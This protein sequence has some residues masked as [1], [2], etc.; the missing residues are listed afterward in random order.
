MS[1]NKWK[2]QMLFKSFSYFIQKNIYKFFYDLHQGLDSGNSPQ[3]RDLLKIARSQKI[4]H[5][6]LQK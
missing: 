5:K 3:L 2:F 4:G 6:N 1:K